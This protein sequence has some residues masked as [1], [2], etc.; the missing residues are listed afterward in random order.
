MTLQI[1]IML[2]NSL[3]YIQSGKILEAQSLLKKILDLNECHAD[4]LRISG[5]V[6]ALQNDLTLALE[7]TNRAIDANP[8]DKQAYCNRGNIYKSLHSPDKSLYDYDRAIELDPYYAEAHNNRGNALQTLNE[9]RE[10]I[11]SYDI[12]IELNPAYSQAFN[13]RGNAYKYLRDFQRAYEN[14]LLAINLNSKYFSA[15]WNL[16]LLQLLVNNYKDGFYNYKNRWLREGA[17]SYLHPYL[18]EPKTLSQIKHKKI[19]AWSEQGYG[20]TLQFCRYIPLLIKAGA[21]VTLETQ[22]PLLPLLSKQFGCTVIE[23]G[24]TCEGYD[25]GIPLGSLPHLFDT[26]INSIPNAL[27]YLQ[28]NPSKNLEW[29]QKLNL[30]KEKLNIGIA[31]SGNLKFDLEN[32]NTRPVPLALFEQLTQKANLY[33]IQVGLRPDDEDYL[34]K[35]PELIYLGASINDFED[36]A[37]IASNMDQII[38]IDTSLAHLAGALNIPTRLLLPYVADWRWQA[39]G[40]DSYWYPSIKLY[41]QSQPFSW[42][43]ALNSIHH[44]LNNAN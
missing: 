3:Q 11:K 43:D 37:A 6:A 4:G 5:V 40:V 30:S 27:P 32:G 19:L 22:P 10:A 24:T 1:D 26:E 28:S 33:L 7:L 20:D 8:L 16:S 18:P 2:H 29:Q 12:A 36:S 44:D 38:T 31:C 41:R 42:E 14:Y 15:Y 34:Q 9:Y 21:V 39:H 23:S 17:D 25:F 35:H 13:N